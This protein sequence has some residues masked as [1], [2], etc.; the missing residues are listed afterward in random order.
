MADTV[1][2]VTSVEQTIIDA[3]AELGLET[4]RWAAPACGSIPTGPTLARSLRSVC[5]WFGDVRC[6]GSL[7]NVDVDMTWFDRHRSRGIA[8]RG[9]TSLAAEGID[10][11]MSEVVE[12][13]GR[14]AAHHFAPGRP[15]ER[16]EVAHRVGR[17]A[18]S[19]RSPEAKVRV[20]RSG[21]NVPGCR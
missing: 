5:D 6:T 2:Y 1:A 13:V 17:P 21:R 3:L 9:V 12:V 18:T 8:D 7:L 4:G 14:H 11:A 16:H 15:V 10:V 19:H 20:R